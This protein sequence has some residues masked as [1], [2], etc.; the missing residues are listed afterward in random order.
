MKISFIDTVYLTAPAAFVLAGFGSL[1][2]FNDS[3][4]LLYLI[5]SP[6]L[7]GA[8]FFLYKHAV[9]SVERVQKHKTRLK[10]K[11]ETE[12]AKRVQAQSALMDQRTV[13]EQEKTKQKGIRAGVDWLKRNV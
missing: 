8:G 12:R 13:Y 9:D 11:T 10:L 5:S 7:F 4:N 2:L 6:I 1:W 3:S